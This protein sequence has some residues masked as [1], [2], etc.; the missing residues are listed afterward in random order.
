MS[1]PPTSLLAAGKV[2]NWCTAYMDSFLDI[3]I[4]RQTAV[5]STA[6]AASERH[7]RD[8]H[9]RW[10]GNTI[11]AHLSGGLSWLFGIFGWRHGHHRVAFG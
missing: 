7:R 6:R 8:L 11:L 9:L 5:Y 4:R 10:N 3:T 1:E 2:V